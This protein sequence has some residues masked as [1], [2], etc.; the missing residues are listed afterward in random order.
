[1]LQ[2]LRLSSPT[3]NGTS[4]LDVEC[5]PVTVIK[6]HVQSGK[7]AAIIALAQKNYIAGKSCLI[8]VRNICYDLEQLLG[9]FSRL[10]VCPAV[11]DIGNYRQILASDKPIIM[12]ALANFHQLG[13]YI[14]A[15]QENVFLYKNTTVIIDE[16][17]HID[18]YRNTLAAQCVLDIKD[19]AYKVYMVSATVM[20]TV[21]QETIMPTN[22]LYLDTPSNYK[23]IDYVQWCELTES[24]NRSAADIFEAD[25][26]IPEYLEEFVQLPLEYSNVHAKKH[27]VLHLLKFS[28]LKLSME[29]IQDYCR[30]VY[31]RD[32]TSIVMNSN[33]IRF[34]YFSLEAPITIGRHVIHIGHDG[35]YHLPKKLHITNVIKYLKTIGYKKFPRILIIAGDMAGRSITFS[36]DDHAEK[37]LVWHLTGMYL[38]VGKKCSQPELLQSLRTCCRADDDIPIKIYTLPETRQA[39]EKAFLLQE[40]YLARASVKDVPIDEQILELPMHWSKFSEGHSVTKNRRV[41]L[42]KV[43]EPDGGWETPELTDVA[44][45]ISVTIVQKLP[46][47]SKKYYN[48]IK[49]A[50]DDVWGTGVWIRKASV[51]EVA[52][53]FV[54]SSKQAITNTTFS[55]HATKA[56]QRSM[57]RHFNKTVD[58][59]SP[60]LLW[61]FRGREWYVRYNV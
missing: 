22:I 45:N 4:I 2:T 19:L 21:L 13:K 52:A 32:I 47:V 55:W 34:F 5:G 35:Y 23:G 1:M 27:P 51:I 56:G 17:D 16:A 3:V 15:L 25:P 31:T 8:I 12:L 6:G 40:E 53:D 24:V 58:E 29:K 41:T 61:K 30:N 18:T 50:I 60:G 37:T 59:N 38:T 28:R 44:G 36:S 20:D 54:D 48:A 49:Q 57:V 7:T 43:N 42:N 26:N 11:L 39:I 14:N 9:R 33:G 10:K 46:T